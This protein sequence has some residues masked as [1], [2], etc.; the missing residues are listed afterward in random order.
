MSNRDDSSVVGQPRCDPGS[1]VEKVAFVLMGKGDWGGGAQ[2]KEAGQPGQAGNAI[3][4]GLAGFIVSADTR[5]LATV[6]GGKK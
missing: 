1:L 4:K 3:S 5:P 6:A 2:V